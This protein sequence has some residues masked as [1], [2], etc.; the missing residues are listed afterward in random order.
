MTKQ[1]DSAIAFG[2]DRLIFEIEEAIAQDERA[3]EH[4][5][6]ELSGVILDRVLV[7][8]VAQGVSIPSGLVCEAA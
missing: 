5:M 6:R 2:R 4:T 3:G 8:L 1:S 7:Q